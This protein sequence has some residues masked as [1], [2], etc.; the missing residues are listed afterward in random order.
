M[1]R[2]RKNLLLVCLA[3]LTCAS[4]VAAAPWYF[5]QREEGCLSFA[6]APARGYRWLAVPAGVNTP[7]QV[8]AHMRQTR[9]PDARLTPLIDYAPARKP[10][11]ADPI[12]GPF[13]RSNAFVVH[14]AADT[15]QIIVVTHAL[16][17]SVFGVAKD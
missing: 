15:K 7:E 11:Q 10:W 2:L 8:H 17:Q 1:T 3:W 6:S 14:D 16:C 9:M 4:A 13:T 5:L 12:G